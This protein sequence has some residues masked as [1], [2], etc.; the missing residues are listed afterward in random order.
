MLA[1]FVLGNDSIIGNPVA[2]NVAS[3]S[4]CIIIILILEEVKIGNKLSRFLGKCSYEIFL[5]HPFVLGELGG[6][7]D[8]NIVVY[9]LLT[10]F[11]TIFLSYVIH[12]ISEMIFDIQKKIVNWNRGK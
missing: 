12:I 9:G 3:V 2:R 5:I 6:L 8:V 4:F 1:F 7:I 10:I 11:I